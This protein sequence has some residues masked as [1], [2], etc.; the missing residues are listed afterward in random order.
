MWDVLGI[1][2]ERGRESHDRSDVT[3]RVA[4]LGPV[5]AWEAALPDEQITCIILTKL[6]S[7]Y[8]YIILTAR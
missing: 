6:I 3:S 5:Y 8:L 7:L 1:G 4:T 2:E